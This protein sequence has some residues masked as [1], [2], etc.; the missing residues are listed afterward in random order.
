VIAN[1]IANSPL[2]AAS[3][4]AAN[5]TMI[6]VHFEA[7]ERVRLGIIGV[8]GRCTNLLP[9]LLAVDGVAV[10]AI[11]DVVPAKVEHAQKM[12]TYAGQP[13]LCFQ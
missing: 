12:V 10:K 7:R 8:G 9:N 13:N 1:E 11:C 2:V 3:S 5:A 6:G 4:K